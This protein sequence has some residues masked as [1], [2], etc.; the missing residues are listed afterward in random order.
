MCGCWEGPLPFFAFEDKCLGISDAWE[1][2][3]HIPIPLL[4]FSPLL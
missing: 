2:G 4:G 1:H 3:V